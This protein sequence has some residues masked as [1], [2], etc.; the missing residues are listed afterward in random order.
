MVAGGGD[1]TSPTVMRAFIN[2]DDIDF[3]MAAQLSP[4]Q[5]FELV[6]DSTASLEYGTRITKFQSVSSLTLY[7]DGG[8]PC[9]RIHFV[10]LRGEV[11]R[12]RSSPPEQ[13]GDALHRLRSQGS[14]LK[15]EAPLNIVYEAKPQPQDHK[16][17]DVTTLGARMLQ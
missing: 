7:F 12:T 10:G 3:G 11:R 5:A 1:G 15:R 17:G 16:V 4:V 2:R 14:G 13:R 6:E 9:T 8:E